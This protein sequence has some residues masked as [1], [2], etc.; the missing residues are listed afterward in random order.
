MH[1]WLISKKRYWGLA[2][3]IWVCESC[4]EFEVLGGEKELKERAIEG[5]D[6]FEGKTP[7]KPYIDGIK[8]KCQ[9][10]GGVATRIPDVGNPWLDA[11]IVP[12]STIANGNQGEPMYM[13]N[14]EEW[15][16]WFPIDFITE[17]FP[18][19]FKN[20]FYSMIAMST[21][22]ENKQPFDRVLGFGTLLAEDGRAMHKSW[23]NSIEFSE[24]A[25]KI[26]ADVM[27]WMYAATNPADNMLFGYKRGD[28]ARRQV[29]IKLWNSY[30]F[31]V[32]NASLT[33]FTP[34]Q[35]IVSPHIL[36]IWIKNRLA[37]LVSVVTESLDAFNAA[38]ATEAM[39][40]FIDDLS[41][42]YIRRSRS[43][44]HCSRR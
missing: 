5:L 16:K 43:A 42:W 31:F 25:D 24:G 36:D 4:K 34:D 13:A 28:E 38:G 3:P 6:E 26:G 35:R 37:E 14:R 44:T 11:G 8:I 30:N 41:N 20:W 10:C 2:L 22:L 40:A 23:G 7:H 29:L 18:G 33:G 15:Q 19:Q 17:S 39:A 9:K 21:V 27:R 12:F 32:M 1:D